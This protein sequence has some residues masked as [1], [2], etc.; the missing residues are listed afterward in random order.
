MGRQEAVYSPQCEEFCRWTWY[1]ASFWKEK[2]YMMMTVMGL[3]STEMASRQWEDYFIIT[4]GDF[5]IAFLC[6]EQFSS[7]RQSTLMG[8]F[9]PN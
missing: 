8:D 1:T 5:H 4:L 3:R 6:T 9:T 7:R 2:I